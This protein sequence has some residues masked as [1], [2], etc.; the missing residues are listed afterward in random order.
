MH[1]GFKEQLSLDYFLIYNFLI[2]ERLF[3]LPLHLTGG[4]NRFFCIYCVCVKSQ[5]LCI[6]LL[7]LRIVFHLVVRKIG[8]FEA[9]NCFTDHQIADT[10]HGFRDSF[11]VLKTYNCY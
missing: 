5:T 3:P 9:K 1:K 10:I 11:A 4:A 8:E 2:H 6:L 7:V